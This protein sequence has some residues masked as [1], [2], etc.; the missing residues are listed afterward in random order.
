MI[1]SG[2]VTIRTQKVID[3]HTLASY[4]LGFLW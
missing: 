3:M 1:E 4:V 2:F